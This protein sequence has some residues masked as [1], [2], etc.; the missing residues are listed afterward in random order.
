MGFKGNFMEVSVLYLQA[1]ERIAQTLK[2]RFNM[3][4]IEFLSA[5]SAKEAFEMYSQRDI[6]LTLTDGFIPDMRI[7]DFAQKLSREYPNMILD[8][9]MDL[10]DPQYI[11]QVVREECVRKVFLPPWNID[12]IVEGVKASIDEAQ[13]KS[14]FV[15][16]IGELRAEEDAFSD[17]LK[18]LKNALL[19]QQYSYNKIAPFFNRVMESFIAHGDYEDSF[20]HFV[21]RSCERMLRLQTTSSFK[22]QDMARLIKTN[23]EESVAYY[24]QVTVGEVNS[25]LFGDV[26]KSKMADLIFVMRLLAKVEGVKCQKAVLS[27][28]SRYI[29]CNNCEYRLNVAGLRRGD[30]SI[31]IQLFTANVLGA[32]VD[33]YQKYDTDDGWVYELR[34]SL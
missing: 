4:E 24:E 14:D 28:D 3:E 26:P 6:Y 32:V 16:R 13:I 11:P 8:V 23:L 21:K 30:V 33:E 9:C 10:A 12:D 5:S 29:T 25:C 1:N 18:G 27:V 2:D 34:F 17:T 20:K 31:D 15:K 7:H 19:K 22:A